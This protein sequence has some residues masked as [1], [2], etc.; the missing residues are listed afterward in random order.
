MTDLTTNRHPEGLLR[1]GERGDES[2]GITE[3]GPGRLT[4]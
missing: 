2:H 1:E 3:A 4:P